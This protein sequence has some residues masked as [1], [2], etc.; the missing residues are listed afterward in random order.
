MDA[1]LTFQGNNV[2]NRGGS[3]ENKEDSCLSEENSHGIEDH[4]SLQHSNGDVL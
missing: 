2:I 3:Y 1:F 4:S